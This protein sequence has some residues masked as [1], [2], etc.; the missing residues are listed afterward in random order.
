MTKPEKDGLERFM[1]NEILNWACPPGLTRDDLL[2]VHSRI[3]A[4]KW[5]MMRIEVRHKD[6]NKQHFTVNIDEAK[7]NPQ[8]PASID[9]AIEWGVDNLAL[10]T[11]K[12]EKS[13]ERGLPSKTMPTPQPLD[14]NSPIRTSNCVF[15][16]AFR[17]S[18]PGRVEDTAG[19]LVRVRILAPYSRPW[20]SEECCRRLISG[21]VCIHFP[22]SVNVRILV[23][24]NSGECLYSREAD[25]LIRTSRTLLRYT[26][27]SGY[28]VSS[29]IIP[30]WEEC[31]QSLAER[32]HRV[33]TM[34]CNITIYRV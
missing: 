6:N 14:D 33:V 16:G 12:P 30:G 2:L 4:A 3:M 1:K 20:T 29:S 5:M 15:L 13:R 25:N 26:T 28:R 27:W 24:V 9:F 17:M 32:V 11:S 22:K 10:Q 23:H 34:R 8:S 18:G 31:I 21:R 7:V 19:R